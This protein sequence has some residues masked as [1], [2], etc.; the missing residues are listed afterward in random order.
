[1]TKRIGN[2]TRKI[3][4]AAA[5]ML[6]ENDIAANGRKMAAYMRQAARLKCGIV[7]F[8]E[9]CLTN[10]PNAARFARLDY[11]LVAREERKLQRLAGRLGLAVLF[12]STSR[13][14]GKVYN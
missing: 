6:S 11:D 10:Y 14:D 2:S 8:H 4:L 3:K 12:G 7:L 1:M 13:K 5:Q 9:G